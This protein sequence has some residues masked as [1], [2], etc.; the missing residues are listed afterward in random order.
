MGVSAKV[1]VTAIATAAMATSTL[2][3]YGVSALGPVLIEDLDLSRPQLGSLVA[4]TISA[5]ALLSMPAGRLIDRIG[6]RRGLVGLTVAIVV[7]LFAA[8]LADSYGWLLAALAVAGVGQAL[9]NPATNVLV[10]ARIPP[11]GDGLAI[12]YKQSG[13]QI[14]ALLSGLVL[15]RVA[16]EHGW[17]WG[18]RTSAVAA[19][20]VLIT[21]PLVQA[22]A[23]HARSGRRQPL[24]PWL[25]RLTLYC[26]VL[27]T[28][29]A[30][31]AAFLP[32]FAVQDLGY[33][34]S[35]GG[36]VLACFGA[37]GFF[38]RIW[39]ARRAAE[40]RDRPATMLT[41]LTCAA[42]VCALP[43][44]LATLPHLGILVW[45]GA[46]G[47]GGSATA[48]Y[49]VAMLEV[50]RNGGNDTGRA[51]GLVSVGFFLGFAAGPV[52]FGFLTSHAG[53]R[54]GWVAVVGTLVLAAA[55]GLPFRRTTAP[56]TEP[57]T[58]DTPA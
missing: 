30:A 35:V 58:P 15:P 1:G 18:L 49:A 38:G 48:A 23:P 54:T 21:V 44:T 46:L 39:W 19:L 29:N 55:A 9:A 56:G 7:T 24:P 51:S 52:A 12:G 33:Q 25:F 27:A 17:Q 22:P 50:V 47:V 10:R 3:L 41:G 11:P 40:R 28:A 37:A 31:V 14:S 26:F 45:V 43:L 53:Y 32:L 57:P 5:A 13:V 4:A 2:P 20:V 42:A 6:A 8:S 16:S 34:P 36:G